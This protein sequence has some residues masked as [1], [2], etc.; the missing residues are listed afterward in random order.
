MERKVQWERMLKHE[1]DAAIAEFPVAYLS[2][3]LCEPHG[4]YNP[5]GLDELKAYGIC[6]RAAQ[7]GGGIVAP[8]SFWHIH[9]ESDGHR[10]FLS[11]ITLFPR[12]LTAIPADLFRRMYLWQLRAAVN[13]GC[14]AV[15]AISGHYGGVEFN[16][17]YYG[18][19]FQKH[20]RPIPIWGL[21]DWEVIY[22]QDELEAYNGSHASL[23]ETCQ[24]T[25]LHPDLPDLSRA[26]FVPPEPYA[27]GRMTGLKQ[28]VTKERGDHIIESQVRN[29]VAGAKRM[30][31][32]GPQET[33]AFIEYDEMEPAVER[34][35][36]DS[37]AIPPMN[38]K[39]GVDEFRERYITPKRKNISPE[40]RVMP[41]YVFPGVE[42]TGS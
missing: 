15:I 39:Q 32:E 36:K 21:A 5:L 16:L 22:Y 4:L 1:L 10:N 35:L 14:R 29:L 37:L 34:I 9:E 7:A 24:L 27:G 33:P 30:L 40:G 28:K 18:K 20:V 11:R 41:D 26:D 31:A 8:P 42:L 38:P 6:V 23:C 12:Y 19:L 3:G 13:A 2:F 17:K 25:S